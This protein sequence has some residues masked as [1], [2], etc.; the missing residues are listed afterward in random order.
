MRGCTQAQVYLFKQYFELRVDRDRGLYPWTG[1][2]VT[3]TINKR[4]SI[5]PT[6]YH[7][8]RRGRVDIVVVVDGGGASAGWSELTNRRLTG[9]PSLSGT[10][11]P[12]GLSTVSKT[13]C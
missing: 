1:P 11:E 7:T 4:I 12:A 3:Q 2:Q 6:C 8:W 5:N 13:G 9:W 10:I